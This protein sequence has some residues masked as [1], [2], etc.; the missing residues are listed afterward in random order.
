ML[1]Q[2][3]PSDSNHTVTL[4]MRNPLFLINRTSYDRYK[5]F[6]QLHVLLTLILGNAGFT[7][8]TS[9]SAQRSS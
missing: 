8:Y 3:A 5:E 9:E 7:V 1:K 6:I 2:K 4:K